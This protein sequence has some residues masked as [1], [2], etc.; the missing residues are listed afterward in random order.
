MASRFRA[1]FRPR[2]KGPYRG[3]GSVGEGVEDGATRPPTVPVE[4]GAAGE[5]AEHVPLLENGATSS[6]LRAV[7]LE[8]VD[9]A[10]GAME[11]IGVL[12]FKYT[13]IQSPLLAGREGSF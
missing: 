1:F 10:I 4:L 2:H 9:D 7:E 6:S 12:P 13:R 11:A 3:S 5:L 8:G